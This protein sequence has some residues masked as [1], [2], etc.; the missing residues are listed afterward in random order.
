MRELYAI[1]DPWGGAFLSEVFEP[2]AREMHALLPE[3]LKQAPVLDA[4]SGEGHFVARLHDL[5][6]RFDLIDINATAVKR[7]QKMLEK[8][9]CFF[10]NQGLDEFKPGQPGFYGVIWCFSILTFLGA[11][12]HNQKA[13]DILKN[14][15]L[16]L[17]PGGLLL[18]IHPFY[19][20]AEK[21]HLIFQTEPLGG[22]IVFEEERSI[23]NQTFLLQAIRKA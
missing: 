2:W 10:S 3:N 19:S 1:Q 6:P 12:K 22:E 7:A 11:L 20:Q 18:A 21:D 13:E 23:N 5:A 17:K 4:G 15:W 16:A 9:P 14:L 8:Y